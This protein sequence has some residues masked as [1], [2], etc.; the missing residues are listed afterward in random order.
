MVQFPSVSVVKIIYRLY[1]IDVIGDVPRDALVM[2]DIP[3]DIT[4]SPH[5]KMR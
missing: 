4:M 1:G 5:R 3:K 2:T